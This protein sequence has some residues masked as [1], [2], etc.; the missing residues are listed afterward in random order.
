MADTDRVTGGTTLVFTD[1]M[2]FVA[3]W[4]PRFMIVVFLGCAVLFFALWYN[5]LAEVQRH[6]F[7]AAPLAGIW[8]FIEDVGVV[9]AS[10]L[11]AA[12]VF[13]LGCSWIGFRRLPVA[14]R[15]LSYEADAQ[16]LATRDGAHVALSIP[17]SMVKEVRSTRR[18]MLFKLN[19]GAWR[20]VPHRAFAADD[21]AKVIQWAKNGRS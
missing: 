21:G 3:V 12:P 6:M 4:L 9:V 20:F 15:V 14:N 8:R 2:A 5:D 13:I 16:E 17:W 18:L 7:R 19:S 10:V 1:Q 11:V